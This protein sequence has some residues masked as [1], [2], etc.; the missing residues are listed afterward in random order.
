MTIY[1]EQYTHFVAIGELRDGSKFRDKY[2]PTSAW[3][4]FYGINFY[5]AK[6]YGVRKETKGR[7][8]LKT[9]WN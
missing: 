1:P 7:V 2:A 5:R 9:V 6:V 4:L 3:T 8:L